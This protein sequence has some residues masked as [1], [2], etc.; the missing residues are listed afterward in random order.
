MRKLT[1]TLALLIGFATI[2]PTFATDKEAKKEAKRIEKVEKQQRIDDEWDAKVKAKHDKWN[3]KN[4]ERKAIKSQNKKQGK[5]PV[6]SHN[7]AIMGGTVV[8]GRLLVKLGVG[9]TPVAVGTLIV[10]TFGLR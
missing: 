4:Q 7:G 5:N 10:I 3:A 6:I 9:L 1:I 2:T 8:A